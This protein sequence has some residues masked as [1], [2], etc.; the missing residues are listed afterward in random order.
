MRQPHDCLIIN[1]PVNIGE[2]WMFGHEL[3]ELFGH[4]PQSSLQ[5]GRHQVAVQTALTEQGVHSPLRGAG[6][7]MLIKAESFAGGTK[8]VR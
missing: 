3:G 5:H 1:E 8:S 7:E 4:G 6:F 2:K